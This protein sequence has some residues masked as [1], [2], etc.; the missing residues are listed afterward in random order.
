[1]NGGYF[2]FKGSDLIDFINNNERKS[3]P[4]SVIVKYG[5]PLKY[6]YNIGIDYLKG[7]DEAYKG[8]GYF[9]NTK[10]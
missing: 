6:N 1:M 4:Y 2:L 8:V 9:E 3:I 7:I 5:Y 10:G